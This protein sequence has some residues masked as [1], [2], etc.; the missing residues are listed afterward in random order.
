MAKP[1]GLSLNTRVYGVLQVGT[2]RWYMQYTEFLSFLLK[3]WVKFSFCF[4]FPVILFVVWEQYKKFIPN[5]GAFLEYDSET[6][7]KAW[8]FFLSM[9]RW[10]CDM[11]KFPQ[12]GK[13]F[14]GDSAIIF[15]LALSVLLH[16]G[17]SGKHSCPWGHLVVDLRT[18]CHWLEAHLLLSPSFFSLCLPGQ[19]LLLWAP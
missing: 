8:R 15:P 11:T 2:Q 3:T 10:Y 6:N 7:K 18:A 4:A 5:N 12:E 9:P 13:V 16:L 1:Q 19:F 17:M 14:D